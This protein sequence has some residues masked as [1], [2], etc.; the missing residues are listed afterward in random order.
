MF[1][2]SLQLDLR[3]QNHYNW[4][5]VSTITTIG[6]TFHKSLQLDLCF[7][8]HYNWT[9]VSKITTIGPTFHKS[10]QL[11]LCFYNHY[12][13]T[14]IYKMTIIGTKILQSRLPPNDTYILFILTTNAEQNCLDLFQ[15]NR[16]N[17]L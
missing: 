3:F 17:F 11:N 16:H 13:W 6:P 2:Q 1:L 14:Y 15:K 5:Y 9:Y 10:L 12:N 7:Y 8:N 4:T